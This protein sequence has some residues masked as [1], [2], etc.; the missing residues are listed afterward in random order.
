ME[1]VAQHATPEPVT[2]LDLGGRD[3]N[4]SPRRLFPAADYT[5]LDIADGPDV[6]VVA[7]ASTWEPDRKFDVVV[8]TELFEHTPVWPA[9]CRT[10]YRALAPG[11]TFIATMAG[12]N[13]PAHGAWGGPAPEPGE[14]YRNIDPDELRQALTAAGFDPVTVDVQANPSDVRVVARK[15]G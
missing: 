13:R 7:D 5:V 14:W 11:G 4:G 9:I 3:N 8:S 15:G 2:V 1:W 10:A 12:P 6:D